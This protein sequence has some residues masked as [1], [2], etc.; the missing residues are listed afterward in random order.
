MGAALRNLPSAQMRVCVLVLATLVPL[1]ADQL[2]TDP[3]QYKRAVPGLT[4]GQAADASKM[5]IDQK[6]VKAIDTV[7]H[8]M[9]R[10]ER[11]RAALNSELARAKGTEASHD[12]KLT[13]GAHSI[14]LKPT[15]NENKIEAHTAVNST[16]RTTAPATTATTA[17]ATTATT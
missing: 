1:R 12:L 14:E 17:P 5:K 6:G 13:M 10:V 15:N 3:A 8:D 2:A 16:T 7:L 9:H 4:N 11:A